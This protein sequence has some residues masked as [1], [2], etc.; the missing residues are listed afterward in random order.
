M[1]IKHGVIKDTEDPI[2]ARL[3]FTLLVCGSLHVDNCKF[4][5]PL[6]T[7]SLVSEQSVVFGKDIKGKWDLGR[8]ARTTD[9]DW[10][11]VEVA[12]EAMG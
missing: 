9:A 8:R 7:V 11:S 2:S 1:L 4:I 5:S 10:I 12:G 6:V 3:M